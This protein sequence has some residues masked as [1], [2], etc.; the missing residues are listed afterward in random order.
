MSV[1]STRGNH[2]IFLRMWGAGGLLT[3]RVFLC[4]CFVIELEFTLYTFR[5]NNISVDDAPDVF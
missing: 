5:F 2:N 4:G 1:L 3:R